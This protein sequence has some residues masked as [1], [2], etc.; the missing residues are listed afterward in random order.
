[1]KPYEENPRLC[2]RVLILGP[3]RCFLDPVDWVEMERRHGV[4]G[5][6]IYKYINFLRSSLATAMVYE[7]L[8]VTW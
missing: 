2:I 5:Q 3:L 1:M 7:R 8:G 6:L 4:R